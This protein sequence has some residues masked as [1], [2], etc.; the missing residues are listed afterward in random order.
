M[1]R[2]IALRERPRGI[3]F[4]NV[5]IK[6]I[7][8]VQN[9]FNSARKFTVNEARVVKTGAMRFVLKSQNLTRYKELQVQQFTNAINI[10]HSDIKKIK[11]PYHK[12][13]KLELDR[14]YGKNS[15]VQVGSKVVHRVES[16]LAIRIL[17]LENKVIFK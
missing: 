17:E 5:G 2:E 14:Y 10:V 4:G 7:N 6:A 8:V 12:R 1:A 9:K 11:D 16:R 13:L 15:P 3:G